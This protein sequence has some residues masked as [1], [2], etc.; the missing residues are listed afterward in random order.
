MYTV[1]PGSTCSLCKDEGHPLFYCPQYKLLS[2]ES[3]GDH[4]RAHKLCYN[5]LSHGHST[6]ACHSSY[7]CKR[8]GKNHHTTLHKEPHGQGNHQEPPTE[9]RTVS[10][11]V[12]N[13]PVRTTP[14]IHP[15]VKLTAY[16]PGG[17]QFSVRAMLDSGSS[18]C[19][20]KTKVAR[21]LQLPFHETSVKI[22]GISETP[23]GKTDAL[24]KLVLTS[25]QMPKARIEITAYTLDKLAG[26]MPTKVLT[27]P[28]E[29][30]KPLTL[31]DPDFRLSKDIDL[32]LGEDVMDDIML[33]GQVVGDK[34]FPRATKTIFGWTVSGRV[35]EREIPNENDMTKHCYH[36]VVKPSPTERLIAVHSEGNEILK[37][38]WKTES[39]PETETVLTPEENTAVLH[40]D[41][42]HKITP[43]G[44]FQVTLP[45][46][47]TPP[48]LG[49]S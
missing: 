40:F 33:G 46:K 5:C 45:R 20:V 26:I 34:D 4:V 12:V 29:F 47:N 35:E 25:E 39:V 8:C 1:S 14:V 16:G 7:K 22:V 6:Q 31:A 19:L 15:T 11:V 36:A 41:T 10:A 30:L 44:R 21:K 49:F 27:Q 38:F 9:Q 42:T 48:P 3:R 37:Q 17:V 28:W 18:V 23:A 2:V 24:V 43:Q 13:G 32:I